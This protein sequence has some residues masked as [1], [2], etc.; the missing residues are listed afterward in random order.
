MYFTGGVEYSRTAQRTA[1][2]TVVNF[3][4]A[5]NPLRFLQA[6][7]LQNCKS[8]AVIEKNDGSTDRVKSFMPA[9]SISASWNPEIV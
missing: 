4:A 5:T 2:S 8:G 1:S 9:V 6:S 7:G 3:S